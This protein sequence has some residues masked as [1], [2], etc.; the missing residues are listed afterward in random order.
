MRNVV[1]LVAYFVVTLGGADS[2]LAAIMIDFEDGPPTI[3]TVPY[4]FGASYLTA[5]GFTITSSSFNHT[6]FST[7]LPSVFMDGGDRHFLANTGAI[8][9]TITISRDPLDGAFNLDS[10]VLGTYNG[11]TAAGFSITSGLLS[12]IGSAAGLSVSTPTFTNLFSVT[13][14]W[15]SGDELAIDDIILSDFVSPAAVPEPASAAFLGLGS[16]ALVVRRLRRR[17]SVVA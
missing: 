3:P 11:G 4:N 9:E 8:G 5:Q 17:S 16:L 10:L 12:Q 1:L 7:N 6:I 14:E 13:I 2:G 15:T